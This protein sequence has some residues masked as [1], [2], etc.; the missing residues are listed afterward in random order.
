MQVGRRGRTAAEIAAELGCA[1]DTVDRAVDRWGEALL[2]ADVERVGAVDALGLDE[3]L[4]QRRGKW[5]TRMWMTS[6]VDVRKGQLIDVFPGR[7]R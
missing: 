6:A 7:R 3:T 1:W 4:F 5:H 2:A